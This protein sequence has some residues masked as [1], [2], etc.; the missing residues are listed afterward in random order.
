MNK[1]EEFRRQFLKTAGLTAGAALLLP[2][3]T[4]GQT[5]IMNQGSESP[6]APDMSGPVDYTLRSLRTMDS[7]PAHCFASRKDSP[8]PS[9]FTTIR[10]RRSSCIGMVKP[11]PPKSTEHPRKAPRLSRLRE[12]SASG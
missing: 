2:R 1:F 8:P 7:S 6:I 5:G 11:Y 10:I 3:N 12:S 9:T 4:F